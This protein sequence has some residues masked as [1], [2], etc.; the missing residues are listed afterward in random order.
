MLGVDL[1]RDL[2]KRSDYLLADLKL[3]VGVLKPKPQ[4]P[5]AGVLKEQAG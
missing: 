1:L 3:Q 5:E 2:L 4:S